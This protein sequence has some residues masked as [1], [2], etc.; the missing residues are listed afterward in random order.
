MMISANTFK[1]NF[2]GG[3]IPPADLMKILRISHKCGVREVSFGLRQQLLMDVLTEDKYKL[4]EDLTNANIEH[5][6]DADNFPNIISS[7]PANEV[8]I[9]KTWLTENIYWS[10]F[11]SFTFKPTLKINISDNGQSFTPLLTGNINWVASDQEN[12]WNL[13]IRF[14]KTN[15]IYLWKEVIHTT[16]VAA[17]SK[18]IEEAILSNKEKFYDN[19]TTD[20]DDLYSLI[21]HQHKKY[22]TQAAATEVNLPSFM[23]P[24][25]EGLNRYNHKFWLGIYR[26]DEKFSIKFLYDLCKLCIETNISEVCSTPWK[27][28]IIKNIIHEDRGLWDNLLG[29]YQINVRHAANELNF[30]VE[31]N[32]KDGL[33]LKS[34]L[35][36]HLHADDI[37]TFGI[38]MGIKTRKKSEI[39]SSIL[40]RRK[41]L[42]RIGKF[43]FFHRYDILCAKDFNPN[44]RTGFVFSSNNYKWLLPEQLRRA[45]ISY[46]TFQINKFNTLRSEKLKKDTADSQKSI[47]YVYKCPQCTYVYDEIFGE[48]QA[49]IIAGTPFTS[50]DDSFT[51]PVCEMPKTGFAKIKKENQIPV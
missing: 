14:P 32:C 12:Y 13:F 28:L 15:I 45:I 42:L 47:S 44:E 5:E 51:C 3:I 4:S 27:S 36:K 1:I 50:L 16:D 31:D 22:N 41:P 33:E 29:K 46:Y 8:F 24:Y 17:Y 40:I 38:C 11:Q 6:I 19:E 7:Y 26:R 30:Q 23:L 20:G 37:R 9:I 2:T 49:D 48:P 35:V 43:E 34:F 18:D 39:F 25:Y 10:I 21:N